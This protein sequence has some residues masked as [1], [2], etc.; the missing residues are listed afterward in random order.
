MPT[1][2]QLQELD[3]LKDIDLF[4]TMCKILIIPIEMKQ[5]GAR[6][7][8]MPWFR[9]NMTAWLYEYAKKHMSKHSRVYRAYQLDIGL[10]AFKQA[11]D[12]RIEKDV[13]NKCVRRERKRRNVEGR[14]GR[15]LRVFF[16]HSK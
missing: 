16:Q 3:C 11:F 4:E 1:K 5:I 7:R 13:Q 8:L 2:E 10:G 14:P 9:V 15:K 6:R 12:H